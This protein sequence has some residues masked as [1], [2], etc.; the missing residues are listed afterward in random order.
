[1]PWL[2]SG[3]RVLASLEVAEGMRARTRGLL[4]RD[5]IRGALW[6][7]RT[8]SIHTC[9]MRFPIDAAFCDAEGKVIALLTMKPWRLSRPRLRA[10]SVVESEAGMLEVWRVKVGTRLEIKDSSA[11]R[12]SKDEASGR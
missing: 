8:R 2:V 3:D 9:G 12:S 10:R 7:P 1:M 11:G 6:L 4:G 5:G